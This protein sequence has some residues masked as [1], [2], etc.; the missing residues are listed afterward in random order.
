MASGAFDDSVRDLVSVMSNVGRHSINHNGRYFMTYTKRSKLFIA[1]VNFFFFCCAINAQAQSFTFT[2]IADTNTTIPNGTETFTQ[3]IP[4]VSFDGTHV[5][6]A[7]AGT[8]SYLKGGI[9]IYGGG[10]L[11]IIADSN[12]SVPNGIG[13]FTPLFTVPSLHNGDIAFRG[14]DNITAKFGVYSYIDGFLNVVA[15]ENTPIPGGTGTFG[16]GT[17]SSSFNNVVSINDG[18]V[19]FSGAGTSFQRGIYTNVG[20]VL[21][22]V[23]NQNT[24]IPGGIGNFHCFTY[25]EQWKS[26]FLGWIL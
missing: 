5:V 9:Y 7:G 15:D 11:D 2:K 25:V 14:F 4:T 6:F 3:F 19:A 24:P 1:L 20:G 21:N 17:V 8:P 23:V 13:K 16:T 26:C 18:S 22:V 10:T 12:T